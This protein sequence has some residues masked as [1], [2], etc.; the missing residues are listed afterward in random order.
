MRFSRKPHT[1]VIGTFIVFLLISVGVYLR[2]IYV[3]ELNS[4]EFAKPITATIEPTESVKV[5]PRFKRTLAQVID[6][7][8]LAAEKN[9]MSY[10]EAASV[11]YPP[12]S[13]KLLA[14]K[15]ERD[16]ELWAS[17]GKEYKL[18]KNFKILGASGTSGPKLREGDEQVPEGIYRILALNPN[19]QFHLSMKLNYPNKFDLFYANKEGRSQPGSNIFIHGSDVS[20]GCLA[21]GDNSIEEL[22][23]VV[24]RVGMGNV[25]VVIAPYDPRYKPLVAGDGNGIPWQKVLYKKIAREFEKFQKL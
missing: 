23:T 13:I 15:E 2:L 1:L 20:I 8:G 22:F 7:Y 16:L 11:A 10:F 19:S 9:L 5:L 3:K 24:Y 4:L 25:Q 17:D 21:V 14:L 12:K 18:I 6:V